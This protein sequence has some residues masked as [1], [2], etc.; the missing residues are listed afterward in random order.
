MMAVRKP[1]EVGDVISTNDIFGTVKKIDL[2][3]TTIHTPQAQTVIIPNKKVFQMP[4]TNYSYLQKRRIDLSV[5]VSYGEDL[6]K[7]KDI[8]IQAIESLDFLRSDT[9]V[10]LFYEEFGD[11]S[12]NFVVRYWIDF[13][14]QVEYRS[15]VSEGIMAIK[16]SYD[17]QGITI[18]FPIR[19]L[20]FGIKGGEKLSD[21]MEN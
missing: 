1:F 10:E 17:K 8:T 9:E 11:S 20:D 7:V 4:I 6:S 12:I 19:T 15:A 2:R 5:G 3:A 16:S 14:S 21:V 13:S 18:P